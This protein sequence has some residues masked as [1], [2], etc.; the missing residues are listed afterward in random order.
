MFRYFS[1][2]SS[3]ID[4][5]VFLSSIHILSMLFVATLETLFSS[6]HEVGVAGFLIERGAEDVTYDLQIVVDRVL[7]HSRKLNDGFC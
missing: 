4:L 1:N 7:V 5:T 2:R 3:F 6:E